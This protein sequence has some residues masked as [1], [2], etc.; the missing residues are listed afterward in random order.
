M[1]TARMR[2]QRLQGR[3]REDGWECT[4]STSAKGRGA[5]EQQEGQN[6]AGAADTHTQGTRGTPSREQWATCG[7]S[8]PGILGTAVVWEGFLVKA[9][10]ISTLEKSQESMAF[11]TRQLQQSQPT[12][13]THRTSG[14]MIS[15]PGGRGYK[16]RILSHKARSH[17]S[18]TASGLQGGRFGLQQSCELPIHPPM[19]KCCYRASRQ[20]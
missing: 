5:S 18:T 7:R 14:L 10:H 6:P 19:L 8:V 4:L 2:S 20:C 1:Q 3:Q 13:C 11:H 9:G 15:R 12:L 17:G 16:A